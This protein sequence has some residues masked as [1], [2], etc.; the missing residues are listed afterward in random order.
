[1]QELTYLFGYSVIFGHICSSAAGAIG[2][3]AST[4]ADLQLVPLLGPVQQVLLVRLFSLFR[5]WVWFS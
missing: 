5:Y 2:S 4:D 1:M 3:A